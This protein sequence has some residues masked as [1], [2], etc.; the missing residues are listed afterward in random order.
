MPE[1]QESHGAE[2]NV[3]SII[4]EKVLRK[5]KGLKVDKPP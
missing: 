1:L 2:V 3:V 5:L 4:K